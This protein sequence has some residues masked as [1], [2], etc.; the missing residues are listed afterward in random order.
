MRKY[1]S[2]KVPT[3]KQPEPREV[4]QFQGIALHCQTTNMYKSKELGTEKTPPNLKHRIIQWS[5]IFLN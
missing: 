3:K 2:K 1:C 4:K 5:F